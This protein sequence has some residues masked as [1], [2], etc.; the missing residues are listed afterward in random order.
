MFFTPLFQSILT[1]KSD[2]PKVAFPLRKNYVGTDTQRGFLTPPFCAYVP[3]VP[4]FLG[5]DG[6]GR[7]RQ[8]RQ[9][10]I[11]MN[12]FDEMLAMGRRVMADQ[13]PI[14]QE[15]SPLVKWQLVETSK[16]KY[17]R[18]LCGDWTI[19]KDEITGNYSLHRYGVKQAVF[20][21]SQEAREHAGK[22]LPMR[23]LRR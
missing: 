11:L 4:S 8:E 7:E 23:R 21:T 16:S 18:S 14:N 10:G 6:N 5:T 3:V 9:S 15:N 2:V 20:K 12:S 1:L 17:L 22:S 19:Y 13:S